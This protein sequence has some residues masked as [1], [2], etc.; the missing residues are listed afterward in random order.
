M[1]TTCIEGI[2]GWCT[3]S[4]KLGGVVVSCAIPMP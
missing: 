2:D 4:Y 3:A 1:S